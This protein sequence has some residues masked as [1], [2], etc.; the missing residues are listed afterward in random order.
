LDL[1]F[2]DL[3]HPDAGPHRGLTGVDNRPILENLRRIVG[4]GIPVTI[5]IP[6]VPTYNDSPAVLAG[7][8]A[9]MQSLKLRTVDLLPYHKLGIGKYGWL[10]RTYELSGV[11]SHTDSQLAEICKFFKQMG[12]TAQIGG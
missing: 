5:R 11:K 10:G 7:F 6:L 8:A 2:F 4:Q 9:I 12:F 3:K 1:V